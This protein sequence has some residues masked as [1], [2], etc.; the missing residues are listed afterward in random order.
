MSPFGVDP[1]QIAQVV[2]DIADIKARQ[3]EMQ[4]RLEQLAAKV[5]LALTDLT[6]HGT[7]QSLS[8]APETPTPA[9]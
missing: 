9:V 2:Q 8:P 1:R 7:G 4:V 5:N 6:D 3:V